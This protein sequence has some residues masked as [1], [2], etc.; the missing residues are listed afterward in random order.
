MLNLIKKSLRLL[1]LG[2]AGILLLI[3]SALAQTESNSKGE[4]AYKAGQYQIAITE[5][6][7]AWDQAKIQNGETDPK[8]LKFA[9]NLAAAYQDMGLYKE[10][11]N[12]NQY[13]VDIR[14]QLLPKN[15]EDI[16]AAQNRLAI[17]KSSLGN[18]KEAI[19]VYEEIYEI[20]KQT[21]GE[22]DPKTIQSLNNIAFSLQKLGK[23]NESLELTTKVVALRKEV[24]GIKAENTLNS[25][26]TLA[27][28]Y[29][30]LGDYPKALQ[31]E[32]EVLKLRKE[33]LG[34]NHPA[35][36]SAMSSI[37]LIYRH[38]GR[39]SES[40]LL[41]ERILKLR[42]ESL[43][44]NHPSTLTSMNN[45]AINYGILGRNE[46]RVKLYEQVLEEKIRTIGERNS[47]TL[48]SMNNL[49]ISYRSIGKDQESLDLNKKTYE[50]C[51]ETLGYEHPITLET[52]ASLATAYNRNRNYLKA[53]EVHSE[54]LKL[55][56]KILGQ[57][58]PQTIS[59]MSSI[60][61]TYGNLERYDEQIDTYKKVY[62]LRKEVLG[63]THP[64]T[65]DTVASLSK[66]YQKQG[67]ISAAAMLASEYI[68]GAELQRQQ[69]GLSAENKQGLFEKYANTYRNFSYLQAED[70][71]VDEAFKISELSKART[72]LESMASQMANRSST[73]PANDRKNLELYSNKIEAMTQLIEKSNSP[74]EKRNLELNK[75]N[76]IADY[77]KL[78][79]TL[80]DKYPKFAQL[81]DV[82][83]VG[84]ENLNKL[85]PQKSIAVSY[86]I[87]GPT[88]SAFII[89][90][91]G[92]IKFQKL[93]DIPNLGDTIEIARKYTS[94]GDGF[95]EAFSIEGRKAWQLANGDY[96]LRDI[97]KSPPK[98]ASP[99]TSGKGVIESLSKSLIE[100]LEPYIKGNS[101]LIISPD[102]PLAQLPFEVLETK[103]TQGANQTNL[104]SKIAID[105]TQSLSTYALSKSL[106]SQLK[107]LTNRKSL[108]AVGNPDYININPGN[109][110]NELTRSA[111]IN[112]LEKVTDLDTLWNP[113]PGTEIEVKKI[114]ALFPN[115]NKV[116]IGKDAT[117][118]NMQKLNESGD[119]KNYQYILM[120]A[121]GYLSPNQPALSSIV[122]G[123]RNKTS[124]A[125][126]YI[127]ATEWSEYNL[128]SDL[129]V[130]SACDSGVG[131]VINGEG[132]MGLP[133]ALFVAGN[134]NTVLS[135]W[136]VDDAATALFM[137][138]FFKKLKSGETTAD[139]LKHT[140]QNFMQSKEYSNPKYWAPFILV[141]AG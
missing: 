21:L 37:A 27:S 117:E 115:S 126:G 23:L 72:L 55:R 41:D 11:L 82:K 139:A 129:T 104:V 134:V 58:H 122:L 16:L 90:P 66:A 106:Q 140:K 100:P 45:L 113:L 99:L 61:A 110:S 91:N 101:L 8:T 59:T 112:N 133:F 10:A 131:K 78:Q 95:I 30:D 130:L 38:L 81:S 28:L 57:K 124:A 18:T 48:R 68:N 105:Y 32:E 9:S 53:L 123:L 80:K 88:I 3:H 108:L 125:D 127:T 13:I 43:G 135:L 109:S 75:N 25:L 47:S 52:M 77:Q 34:E 22:K 74:E 103:S 87:N 84:K 111:A 92:N 120:S 33:T 93:A 31:I 89:D 20:R 138:T 67:N 121:H 116:L 102:G 128:K 63:D 94:V 35:T 50:L 137:E 2:V 64:H 98:N 118:Q 42:T 51:T 40:L 83:I 69:A 119:I 4:A 39:N 141:G 76:L 132:V 36:L 60:A 29:V 65:V 46:E 5:F 96:V 19:K 49:A 12:L 1:L 24:L 62:A 97:S 136:P 6:K 26:N 15:H 114:S 54:L 70:N 71:H 79:K 14:S 17:N 86:L 44:P 73:I 85:I 7:Q 107:E 56:T